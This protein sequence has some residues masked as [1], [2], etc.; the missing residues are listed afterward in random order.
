MELGEAE[1]S[2]MVSPRFAAPFAVTTDDPFVLQ[3][4]GS[5]DSHCELST[6]DLALHDV[7]RGDAVL[8]TST[9]NYAVSVDYDNLRFRW[10]RLDREVEGGI[11]G[12]DNF[13]IL[14]DGGPVQLV[15]SMRGS[16][17]ILVRDRDPSNP[18]APGRLGRM[19]VGEWHSMEPFGPDAAAMRVAAIGHQHVVVRLGHGDDEELQLI[20]VDDELGYDSQAP[21]TL[22]RGRA[23]ARV[24]FTG[25]D[26]RVVVTLGK[27]S[28][29]DTVVYSVPDGRVLDRFA[30]EMVSGQRDTDDL[31]GLS[32]ASPDGSHVAYRTPT[33]AVALRDLEAASSCVVRSA[34]GGDHTVA[35]F[36]A[37]GRL[38]MQAERGYE[39]AVLAWDP[40]T[41]R[42]DAIATMTQDF[43]LSA[44]PGRDPVVG[45]R[46][47]AVVAGKDRYATIVEGGVPQYLPDDDYV[48]IPRD[49]VGMFIATTRGSGSKKSLQVERIEPVLDATQRD[50]TLDKPIEQYV[51]A[52]NGASRVC[53]A[54]SNPGVSYRCGR[55]SNA[56]FIA[57]PGLPG[58]EDPSNPQSPGDEVPDPY[59][60]QCELTSGEREDTA[61]SCQYGAED[62]CCYPN[63]LD[64][65]QASGCGSDDCTTSRD[66]ST[67]RASCSG[68]SSVLD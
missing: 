40:S 11:A 17:W 37:Q 61:D 42:L 53:M 51:A 44:V 68:S 32:A 49:D 41:Q 14:P 66:G 39:S 52:I 21:L 27:G 16:D 15:A 64:A 20:A 50:Y 28:G 62:G 24:V 2:S 4:S 29:A 35:G 31:P 55:A 38:Y 56:E 34:R 57:A 26:D 30:G 1:P 25:F 43:R 67:E 58:T 18:D 7:E 47:W 13:P 60:F 54:T 48:F 6:V 59:A 3:C 23:A 46:P 5:D 9:G 10:F 33:G 36:S 63:L 8:L 22:R 45:G 65:C 19:L 12:E